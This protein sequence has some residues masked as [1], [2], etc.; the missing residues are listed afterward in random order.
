MPE[1][2]SKSEIKGYSK[3]DKGGTVNGYRGYSKIDNGV[4][5]MD[6]GVQ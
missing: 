5:Y 4:Q 2:D 1:K 6:K 3:M